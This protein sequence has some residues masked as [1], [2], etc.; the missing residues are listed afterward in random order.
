[1]KI[2]QNMLENNSKMRIIKAIQHL[3]NKLSNKTN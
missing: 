2:L 1:M 3:M